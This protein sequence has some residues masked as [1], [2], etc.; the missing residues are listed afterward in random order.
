M[1][2]AR[3]LW[4]IDREIIESRPRSVAQGN[5]LKI[6]ASITETEFARQGPFLKLEPAKQRI[7]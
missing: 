7:L 5:A 4:R 2:E 3:S 1:D 6:E